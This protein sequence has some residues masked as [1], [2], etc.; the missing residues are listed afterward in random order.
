MRYD[1]FHWHTTVING[2]F[3]KSYYLIYLEEKLSLAGKAL[4]MT[5]IETLSL[6]YGTSG[7]LGTAY[8]CIAM[9]SGLLAHR[10][11]G[12]G[13]GHQAGDQGGHHGGHHGG[14]HGHAH[15]DAGGSIPA[16]DAPVTGQTGRGLSGP[17]RV[18]GKIEHSA[19]MHLPH[20]HTHAVWPVVVDYFNPTSVAIM[21]SLGGM[22]GFLCLQISSFPK[23]LSLP[24]A[25]VVGLIA[26]KVFF[27]LLEK[28]SEVA[29]VSTAVKTE[30]AIGGEATV[31]LPIS[32]GKTGEVYYEIGG[33]R[34]NSSARAQDENSSFVRGQCVRVTDIKEGVFIVAESAASDK[35]TR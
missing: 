22:V 24:C 14:S 16:G 27:K 6:I 12:H 17:G 30:T 13:S 19:H 23:L 11:Q 3:V 9:S 8:L 10:H 31:C 20:F 21:L 26:R 32:S 5:D 29:T 2:V 4:L 35:T 28:F 25:I 15:G 1:Y 33:K 18:L 7:I 34:F